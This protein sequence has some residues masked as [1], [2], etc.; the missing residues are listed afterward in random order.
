[1]SLLTSCNQGSATADYY[2][3]NVSTTPA[4]PVIA[5]PFGD[6]VIQTVGAQA[7]LTADGSSSILKLGANQF[8]YQN[9]VLENGATTVNTDLVMEGN[10]GISGDLDMIH[11]DVVLQAGNL[12]LGG[13]DIKGWFQSPTQTIVV[14][15]SGVGQLIANPTGGPGLYAFTTTYTTAGNDSIQLSGIAYFNGT[16]WYGG[17]AVS[18]AGPGSALI[19]PNPG[20]TQLQIAQS[21]GGPV[22]ANFIFY[23]VLGPSA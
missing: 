22:T 21:G 2:V 5:A 13:G 7:N 11:G 17:S 3:K 9:I 6:V 23:K 4:Y 20:A 12:N 16:V 14:P 10:V 19:S 18:A 1:M 8:S 15:N